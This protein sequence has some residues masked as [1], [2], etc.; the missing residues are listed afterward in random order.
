MSP[1]SLGKAIASAQVTIQSQ[2]DPAAFERQPNQLLQ[3]VIAAEVLS[4]S[5]TPAEPMEG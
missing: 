2:A 4:M 5:A 1:E 3:G